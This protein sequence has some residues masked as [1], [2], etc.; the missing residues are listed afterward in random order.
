MLIY[1]RFGSY[2]AYSP[3]GKHIYDSWG[4]LSG[5]IMGDGSCWISGVGSYTI[6]DQWIIGGSRMQP[7][8]ITGRDCATSDRADV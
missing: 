8:Y 7:L 5:Y 6:L 3:D 4:R 1:D 2:R